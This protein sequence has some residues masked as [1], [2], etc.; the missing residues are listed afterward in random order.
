MTK[1]PKDFTI[2]AD[3][4]FCCAGS[5]GAIIK[6][7]N[8]VGTKTAFGRDANDYVFELRPIASNLPN[9]IVEDIKSILQTGYNDNPVLQKWKW[10]AG[11]SYK[12][13]PFGGHIHFGIKKDVIS[14]ED[15]C[16][17]ILDHYLG[18]ITLLLENYEQAIARRS[19]NL[20]PGGNAVAYGRASDFRE[21]KYGFEYRTPSSW[22]TSP[23][24]ALAIL[25]LA[26]MVMYEAIN[27]KSFK[28]KYY[29]DNNDFIKVNTARLRRIF[30]SLW[31]DITKMS[32]YKKYAKQL[33]IIHDLI[34]DGKD[35]LLDKNDMK[36][37][38][39]IE[40][41]PSIPKPPINE[42]V[43]LIKSK[44]SPAP[45]LDWDEWF[46]ILNNNG[47][48]AKEPTKKNVSKDKSYQI[49]YSPVH[50]SYRSIP[51]D[52]DFFIQP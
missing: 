18:S 40:I 41:P 17:Q 47:I 30:P 21:K 10:L 6:A 19:Y 39:G 2:G 1:N 43:R 44:P 34:V 37:H 14:P 31:E 5:R 49:F 23:K 46:S 25:C 27:N 13:F 4:E 7:S 11:S 9:E 15:A 50:K 42:K 33:K 8:Y 36:Y 51:Q 16:T 24:I 48:P 22:I 28:F 20:T 38:W 32:L 3:P 26:K 35:W 12:G 52:E 29:V 45:K